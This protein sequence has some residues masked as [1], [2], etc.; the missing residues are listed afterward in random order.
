MSEDFP[1]GSVWTYLVL[2]AVFVAVTSLAYVLPAES[3]LAS[4]AGNVGVVA[5]VGGAVPVVP[6]SSRT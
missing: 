5:L 4:I 2:A 6:R 1:R 3:V